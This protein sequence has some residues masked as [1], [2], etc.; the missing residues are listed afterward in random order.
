MCYGED[1][2]GRTHE[3]DGVQRID[4]IRLVPLSAFRQLKSSTENERRNT[5][6]ASDRDGRR[7]APDSICR[8]LLWTNEASQA[9]L[10][11]GGQSLRLK[12]C[13]SL[14]QEAITT[15]DPAV[16]TPLI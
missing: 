6:I 5:S 4:M 7:T 8:C 2:N 15:V 16:V 12:T 1:S 11:M 14:C 13:P 9:G 3:V 10:A